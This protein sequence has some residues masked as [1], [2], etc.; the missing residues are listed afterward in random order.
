VKFPDKSTE[1]TQALIV[2]PIFR[3]SRLFYSWM[4]HRAFYSAGMHPRILTRREFRSDDFPMYFDNDADIDPIIDLPEGFWYGKIDNEQVVRLVGEIASRAKGEVT[5][6]HFSGLDEMFPALLDEL[7]VQFEGTKERITFS[8]VQYDARYHFNN[9]VG[10]VKMRAKISAALQ[11]L[12]SV[13]ILLLDDRFEAGLLPEFEKQV[14]VIPDPA[15]LS[16]RVIDRIKAGLDPSA[17]YDSAEKKIR[18]VAL[19]R[20]SD[21]KGL[22]DIIRAARELGDNSK[23]RIYI[24]GPLE[25]E[26]ERYRTPLAELTPVPIQWRDAYVSEEEIRRTYRDADYL[27]LPYDRSFEGSSGVFA[28]AAAFSKP[29]IATD[30]GCIGYR[31]KRHGLGYVYPAGHHMALARIFNQL[32][33]PQSDEYRTMQGFVS[34]YESS[35]NMAVFTER[36]LRVVADAQMAVK[37]QELSINTKSAAE[38]SPALSAKVG[39]TIPGQVKGATLQ[40]SLEK[41]SMAPEHLDYKQIMLFDTSVSSRNIGDQIIMESIK[42]LLRLAFPKSIFV[43]VPTHEYTGTEALKLIENSEHSFVCGTNLLASH[44]NDY[45][46]WKLQGTDAFLLSGLT[47]L[48]VGWWQ[49]QQPPNAYTQFL[50]RRI[51]SN[52]TLHSVRDEY[53][54]KQLASAGITNVLNTCCPTTWW[55]TPRH[56]ARIP[57][58]KRDIVVFTFTDYA[59]N[60]QVDG[61]IIDELTRRYREVYCWLQ[62]ANDY[63]YAQSFSSASIKYIAPTLEAY[64]EFLEATDC[65]YV[66]TRLHGGIRALQAG[67]RALILAVD[68]RASEISH[69]VGLPVIARDDIDALKGSLDRGWDLDI[70]VPFSDVNAWIRQFGHSYN[71]NLEHLI[72]KLIYGFSVDMGAL[73]KMQTPI[74]ISISG[75]HKTATYMH[76]RVQF[77]NQE[78]DEE[79]AF[80]LYRTS[81]TLG[82][83]FRPGK[84]G[85]PSS[86][87][88]DG[89]KFESDDYG[90]YFQ[91]RFRSGED[92]IIT[93]SDIR[94]ND[95]KLFGELERF[96][97]VVGE[98]SVS[99]VAVRPEIKDKLGAK[100]MLREASEEFFRRREIM[101][102][103]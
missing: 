34:H 96:F 51:L 20:Q 93:S 43:N 101:R 23:T 18:V 94:S 22:P 60:H 19:G 71:F 92:E 58:E 16:P 54:K 56:L 59:K 89:L 6:V 62:G 99:R 17:L 5:H 26:Q 46:Q 32:S 77:R 14:V 48:G 36:L 65:D 27:L 73:S 103:K 11:C 38:V 3:A 8:M 86:K 13:K 68:N 72:D 53:T 52:T 21:R 50:Y 47:L 12:P 61:A 55:L 67:R 28:Y 31:I 42:P 39:A 83:T 79:L 84:E 15:P 33:P 4:A 64:T 74:L 87:L 95:D 2:D 80:L 75:E 24:S 45:K 91:I 81:D 82:I 88:L 9:G 29:I 41:L 69:D 66:G 10:F 35:H 97:G 44:V 78:K 63:E 85:A 70:H 90:D 100:A 1:M 102:T 40:S 37:E 98:N 49:Y 30:H 76:Y 57:K 25:A 7:V